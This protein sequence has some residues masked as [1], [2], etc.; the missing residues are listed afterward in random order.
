MAS[1]EFNRAL[2][3]V[4]E[5]NFGEDFAALSSVDEIITK[6]SKKLDQLATAVTESE[7]QTKADL[8]SAVKTCEITLEEINALTKKLKDITDSQSVYINQLS[9]VKDEMESKIKEVNKF[10]NKTSYWHMLKDIKAKSLEL[11]TLTNN[12]SYMAAVEVYLKLYQLSITLQTSSCNHLQKFSYDTCEHWYD[13]LV[14]ALSRELQDLLTSMKYPFPSGISAPSIKKE[15]TKLRFQDAIAMIAKLKPIMEASPNKHSLLAEL[16]A[17]PMKK[18]FQFHFYGER[19]TN[20]IEKPEWFFT[21]VVNWIRDHTMFIDEYVDAVLLQCDLPVIKNEWC[22]VLVNLCEQKVHATVS[23]ILSDE[24][25]LA[26]LIDE[27]ILF[28]KE[29]EDV[30]D[31]EDKARSCVR[32]LFADEVLSHWLALERNFATESMSQILQH[33]EA[34]QPKYDD[35]SCSDEFK[36]PRCIEE[37]MLLLAVMSDRHRSLADASVQLQFVHLQKGILHD[38]ITQLKEVAADE[39]IRPEKQCHC[40]ILNG[41]FYI[42]NVLQEWQ[43]DMFYVRLHEKQVQSSTEDGNTSVD[44][45]TI[46]SDSNDPDASMFSDILI[47]LKRF[48]DAMIEH[49]VEYVKV[50][51]REK[52]NHYRNDR[53]HALPPLKDYIQPVLLSSACGMMMYIKDHLLLL[54]NMLCGAAFTPLWQKMAT[55]IDE[56]V[57]IEI[58][59]ECHFNEGGAAQ[60]QFDMKKYLF[61]LFGDYTR[62]PEAYFRLMSESC[63]LLNVL[64]G[65]AVLL[66]DIFLQL[67][68]SNTKTRSEKEA[69]ARSALE[70]LDIKKLTLSQAGRIL[71]SRVDWPKV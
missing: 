65:T 50:G 33:D 63:T 37:F 38:F 12:K 46:G 14:E 15:D 66:K 6:Y 43:N 57:F 5:Q 47:S 23:E 54:E 39:V 36:V 27:A 13:Y 59:H 49:I 26:H 40:S 19:H 21:Q 3:N 34:W 18:R 70:E 28:E 31:Y 64:P 62:R 41:T 17:K 20:N 55:M 52:L 8:L 44:S 68:Q 51:L 10:Q 16:L 67:E 53:W 35:V 56:Y 29:L 45:N 7:K 69:N 48:A 2:D 11:E 58:P 4:L 9:P 25:L 22:Q 42:I 30:Y 1:S 61:V 24:V 60:L 71:N 32:V